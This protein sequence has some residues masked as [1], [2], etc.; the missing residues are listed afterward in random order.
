MLLL[1]AVVAA[2]LGAVRA[3]LVPGPLGPFPVAMRDQELTDHSRWDPYA[4]AHQAHKRRILVSVFLPLEP[5][6]AAET[7]V[8][9]VP[10][11]PPAT[12]ALYGQMAKSLASLDEDLFSRFSIEYHQL[13][14]AQHRA[15]DHQ[16]PRYPAVLFSPGLGGPRLVYSAIARSLSSQGYVVITIDHPYDASI[17]EFPDGSVV[18]GTNISTIPDVL[19]AIEVSPVRPPAGLWRV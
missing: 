15:K 18:R 14:P 6:L 7:P 4:P 1:L 13:P 10:Y 19:R 8:R 12:A 16:V 2:S 3:L 9:V 17:V 11:M 5:G